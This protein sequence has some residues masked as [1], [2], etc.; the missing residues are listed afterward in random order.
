M[1]CSHTIAVHSALCN[2]YC[3]IMYR[4]FDSVGTSLLLAGVKTSRNII[5]LCEFSFLHVRVLLY[6]NEMGVGLGLG[7]TDIAN[8]CYS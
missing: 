6:L 3:N 4:V 1:V 8:F 5:M 7:N 2:C